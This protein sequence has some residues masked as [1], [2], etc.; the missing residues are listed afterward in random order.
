MIKRED[1]RISL[2]VLYY[3]VLCVF[4]TCA[5]RKH[6]MVVI[7]VFFFGT[8][9]S[10]IVNLLWGTE[11]GASILHVSSL[12]FVFT[13]YIYEYKT[14]LYVMSCALPFLY[15]HKNELVLQA[16]LV[17]ALPKIVGQTFAPFV[18]FFLCHTELMCKS[19]LI[20]H[21]Q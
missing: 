1:L 3:T 16:V 13:S 5:F 7:N 15:L 21:V 10:G 18:F 11:I 20:A 17:T 14:L 4:L 8:L 19:L 12:V 2:A 6:N 9:I